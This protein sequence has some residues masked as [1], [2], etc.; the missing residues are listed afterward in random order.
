MQKQ[1]MAVLV[2]RKKIIY[3]GKKTIQTENNLILKTACK[4]SRVRIPKR[5]KNHFHFSYGRLIIKT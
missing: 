3:L 5:K 2:R 1:R 4:Y